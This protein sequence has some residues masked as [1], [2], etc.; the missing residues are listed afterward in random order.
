MEG[1]SIAEEK[2]PGGALSMVWG[3]H[4][5]WGTVY[6]VTDLLVQTRAISV[7]KKMKRRGHES[8]NQHNIE[9]NVCMLEGGVSLLCS[10]VQCRRQLW[11][12]CGRSVMFYMSMTWYVIAL[13]RKTMYLPEKGH[14]SAAQGLKNTSGSWSMQGKQTS[15]TKRW[16]FST[17]LLCSYHDEQESTSWG[18][19]NDVLV[20]LMDL[21]IQLGSDYL[22]ELNLGRNAHYTSEQTIRELLQCVSLVIDEQILDDVLLLRPMN[23]LTLLYL[24]SWYL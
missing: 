14:A 18:S 6:S 15:F 5:F 2:G 11:E 10:C 16:W 9:Y 19:M 8:C 13:D 24:S 4:N 17:A 21:S 7:G 23:L 12:W 1:P 20:S 22:R 3:D